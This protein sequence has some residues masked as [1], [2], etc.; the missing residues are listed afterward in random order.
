ME[1][2]TAEEEL[3]DPL[4]CHRSDTWLSTMYLLQEK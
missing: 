3:L 1:D 4:S 2:E